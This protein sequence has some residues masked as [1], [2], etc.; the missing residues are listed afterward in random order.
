MTTFQLTKIWDVIMCHT[1]DESFTGISLHVSDR[2]DMDRSVSLSSSM[3]D[4]FRSVQM[5]D[6]TV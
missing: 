4:S 5:T 1:I 6:R 3:L 2:L